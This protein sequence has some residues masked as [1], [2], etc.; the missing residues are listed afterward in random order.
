[1]LK[2]IAPLVTLVIPCYNHERFV[3]DC[4]QSI[5]DQDYRNIE[6]IIIDDGSKDNSI[7]KIEEMIPICQDRFIRFEFRSRSNKGVS[8]TLNEEIEWAAGQYLS[9]IASDDLLHHNKISFL[10]NKFSLLDDTYAVIF[11][12]VNFINSEGE[13][14]YI[15]KYTRVVE[16]NNENCTSSF[17]EIYTQRRKVKYK[18]PTVF[19]SYSSLLEGN[20]LPAMGAV[21]KTNYVRSS[22]GFTNGVRVEDWNI[23]LKLSKNY[24]FHYEQKTVAFYRLHGSNTSVTSS[25]KLLLD[26]LELL[27]KEECYAIRNGYSAQFFSQKAN[28]ILRLMGLDYSYFKKYFKELLHY[29]M[30][31]AS[32]K[33]VFSVAFLKGKGALSRGRSIIRI[34]GSY[35]KN[36]DI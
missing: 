2:D 23:W 35:R 20:Y 11:G 13:K 32:I 36:H 29:Q 6:L 1:M 5:I 17:L 12:D 16:A 10:M 4:I 8:A 21:F 18:A 34:R 19:G 3:Q 15:N 14:I 22:G 9:I 30:I 7:T 27:Q 31:W 33:L 24:R 26:S 28:C 25:E